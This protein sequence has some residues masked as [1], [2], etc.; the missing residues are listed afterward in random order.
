M[1]L[2]E[3]IDCNKKRAILRDTTCDQGEAIQYRDQYNTETTCG[4]GEAS[5]NSTMAKV[6]KSV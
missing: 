1:L 2:F 3:L 4:Q 6:Q 5:F